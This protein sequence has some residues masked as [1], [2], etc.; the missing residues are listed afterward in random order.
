MCMVLLL[1]HFKYLPMRHS[2]YNHPMYMP[3]YF[4]ML[5]HYQIYGNGDSLC[6]SLT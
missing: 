6:E 2:L 3:P 5:P 1:L 4:I